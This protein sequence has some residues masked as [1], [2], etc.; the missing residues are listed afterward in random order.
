MVECNSRRSFQ[1]PINS[2]SL[3]ELEMKAL[4]PTISALLLTIF[5]STTALAGQIPGLRTAGQIPAPR[6]AG[7]IPAPRSNSA[8][9]SNR[10]TRASWFDLDSAISGSFAGVIR[11]LL[12]SGALL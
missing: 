1:Y 3:G 8:V 9:Q 6:T 7:H 2:R 11:M 5:L 12:D 4:Q 10:A